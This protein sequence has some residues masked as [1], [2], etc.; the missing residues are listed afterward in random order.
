MA[1]FGQ[2]GPCGGPE[3]RM[4]VVSEGSVELL[5]SSHQIRAAKITFANHYGPLRSRR[6]FYFA[7]QFVELP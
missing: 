3:W 7:F 5:Q 6:H 1:T 2:S 4:A